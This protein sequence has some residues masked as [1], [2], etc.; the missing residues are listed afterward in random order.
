[1]V[2]D[3]YWISGCC[4]VGSVVFETIVC[5]ALLRV[6]HHKSWLVVFYVTLSGSEELRTP[7]LQ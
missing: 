5:A 7:T 3:S 2:S 6:I 1:M 4:I